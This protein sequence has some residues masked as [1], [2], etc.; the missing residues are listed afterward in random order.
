[1]SSLKTLCDKNFIKGVTPENAMALADFAARHE[2][3]TAV[4][5]VR[6]YIQS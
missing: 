1:V 2:L 5:D 6:D 3:E 4:H